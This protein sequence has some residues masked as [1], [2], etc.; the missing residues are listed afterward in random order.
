MSDQ[1]QVLI[2]PEELDALIKSDETG[3][4]TD[5]LALERLLKTDLDINTEEFEGLMDDFDIAD[6]MKPG[7]ADLG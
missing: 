7:Y 4:K 5:G 2:K 3:A 1:Q 6:I